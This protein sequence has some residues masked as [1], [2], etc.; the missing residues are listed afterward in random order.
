VKRWRETMPDG[1][2]HDT[3]DP[4]DKGILD[5]TAVFTE[6]AGLRPRPVDP[7]P[8]PRNKPRQLRRLAPHNP[9]RP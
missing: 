2:S 3:R 8:F 5:N 7:R 4:Q 9:G 1:V 6:P